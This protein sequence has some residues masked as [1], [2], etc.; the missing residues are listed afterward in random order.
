MSSSAAGRLQRWG[1]LAL[2]VVAFGLPLYQGL[3]SVDLES[4]ESLYSM[5]VEQM[6]ADGDWMTPHTPVPNQL[7]FFLEKPPLKFW[8]V[9]APIRL[10]LLPGNEFGFRFWDA[11]FGVAIFL[12]VFGLGRLIAGPWCGVSAALLLFT[13]EPLLLQHGLRTNNMEGALTLAYCGGMYHVVRWY[14]ED[15]ASHRVRHASTVGLFCLLGLMTKF[16]AVAFLPLVAGTVTML[17]PAGRERLRAEWRTWL[18]IGAA[19]LALAA[20]WFIYQS[21]VTGWEFWRI[22][23]GEHVF[24][25][26]GSGLDPTHVRPWSYYFVY[27]FRE[28]VRTHGVWLVTAG[29]ALVLVRALWREWFEGT[30]LVF[31]FAL[32]LASISLGSSKLPHYVYPFVPPLALMGG[33]LVA[34]AG[35]AA[36][37]G[38]AGRLP[39]WR[40]DWTVRAAVAMALLAA[41]PAFGYAEV[42]SRLAVVDHPLRD[43][44]NCMRNVR[45]FERSDGGAPTPLFVWLPPWAYQHSFYY[46]L[47][48]VGWSLHE[49]WNDEALV[50][51]LDMVG[52]QMAVLMPPKDYD[53]FQARTGRKAVPV[54]R[55]KLSTAT[56]LLPGPFTACAGR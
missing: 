50:N 36:A 27:V 26:F 32:P 41:G 39:A 12:Y 33:A 23:L 51:A 40:L 38:L 7:P 30:L 3:G 53:V 48:D 31:W 54:P 43:A 29:S 35:S 19:S 4:D 37:G 47:R 28:L 21:V 17:F 8:L 42:R 9:A 13:F 52:S 25:R 45:A 11:T 1:W 44:R 22:I 56:L 6:V 55:R 5:V 18:L 20:P 24:R 2:V 10:G 15:S 14:R 46:Y 49:D 34:A 16:V